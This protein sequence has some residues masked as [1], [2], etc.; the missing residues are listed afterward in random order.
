MLFATSYIYTCNTFVCGIAAAMSSSA[1]RCF[2]GRVQ[3]LLQQVPAGAH[4]VPASANSHLHNYTPCSSPSYSSSMYTAKT[5]AEPFDEVVLHPV[6]SNIQAVRRRSRT[7]THRW[8]YL[9]C[10]IEG[11]STA[12]SLQIPS[13]QQHHHMDV[14]AKNPM[15][16]SSSTTECAAYLLKLSGHHQ[17]AAM[18]AAM[19]S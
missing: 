11:K 6:G 13:G 3:S 5:Y 4:S 7:T 9:I 17:W 18:R 2:S 19:M 16:E 8:Y 10:T 1:Y 14:L 12:C 15:P